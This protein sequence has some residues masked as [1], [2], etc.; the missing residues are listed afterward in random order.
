MLMQEVIDLQQVIEEQNDR[1][2]GYK[3][4]EANHN[5]NIS[6]LDAKLQLANSRKESELHQRWLV[7]AHCK[8]LQ[9]EID[10]LRTLIKQQYDHGRS[11]EP[12]LE[13]TEPNPR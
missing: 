3:Y 1:I 6:T 2:N 11:N 5:L 13:I 12:S 9:S 8:S 4:A 10:F 7:E